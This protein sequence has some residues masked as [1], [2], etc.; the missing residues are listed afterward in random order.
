MYSWH[1]L[2]RYFYIL[3]ACSSFDASEKAIKSSLTEAPTIPRKPKKA[4]AADSEK[5][6][7]NG[8][9]LPAASDDVVMQ[10]D[11]QGVKRPHSGDNEQPLKKARL[12]T[13]A[14]ED[15][16]TVED[17]GGAIVIED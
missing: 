4:A 14:V 6:A 2:P 1:C 12:S 11:S 13:D 5:P 7:T 9:A 8:T 17:D 16:V 10:V 3:T 15:V